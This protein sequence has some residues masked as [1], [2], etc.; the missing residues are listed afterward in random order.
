MLHANVAL[1]SDNGASCAML[2]PLSLTRILLE[3]A[4]PSE[5]CIYTI[6]V[7][8]CWYVQCAMQLLQ[9]LHYTSVTPV[10]K[11]SLLS[12]FAKSA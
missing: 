7:D 1:P 5:L 4:T 11:L 9:E 12:R 10:M 8:Y 3:L 6:T 2:T